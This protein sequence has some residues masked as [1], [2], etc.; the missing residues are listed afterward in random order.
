MMMMIQG[1]AIWGQEGEASLAE[2]FQNFSPPIYKVSTHKQAKMRN[3]VMM[4]IMMIKPIQFQAGVNPHT[5]S[6]QSPFKDV[7]SMDA[8][9]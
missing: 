3:M 4:M 9:P 8:F 2:T 1:N 6:G 5:P 7:L